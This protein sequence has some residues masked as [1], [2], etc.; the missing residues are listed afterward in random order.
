MGHDWGFY[1]MVTDLPKYMRDVLSFS[2]F[3]VGLYSSL[4]YISMWIVSLTSGWFS[5]YLISRQLVTI[6]F[7]RKIFTAIGEYI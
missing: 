6:T 3:D 7:A 2:V 5:D 4:P 1:I